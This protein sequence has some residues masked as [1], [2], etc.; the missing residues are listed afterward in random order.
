M[1]IALRTPCCHHHR[2]PNHPTHPQISCDTLSNQSNSKTFQLQESI[3]IR[4]LRSQ[5]KNQVLFHPRLSALMSH[6]AFHH[7]QCSRSS[8]RD[9]TQ[10]RTRSVHCHMLFCPSSHLLDISCH[11]WDRPILPIHHKRTRVHQ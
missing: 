1:S 10:H 9:P 5:S 2:Y 8:A 6:S 3:Q 11:T 7:N 4:W